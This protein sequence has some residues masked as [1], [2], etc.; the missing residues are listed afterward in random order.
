MS[1]LHQPWYQHM[2]R[3]QLIGVHYCQSET[4]E[5]MGHQYF[6]SPEKP[7]DQ[8]ATSV[9]HQQV[10]QAFTYYFVPCCVCLYA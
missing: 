5:E 7:V 10:Q 2:T 6:D 3:C 8:P 9:G 1:L 4:C